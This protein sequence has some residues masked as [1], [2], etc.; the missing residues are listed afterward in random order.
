M[1]LN[2][3]WIHRK[4]FYREASKSPRSRTKKEEV[5][6]ELNETI[7]ALEDQVITFNINDKNQQLEIAT[8]ASL[9]TSFYITKHLECF[10][11]D[12]R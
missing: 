5:E 7:K 8:S 2:Y 3:E 1:K 12:S 9:G 6:Q 10:G 4:L 11:S